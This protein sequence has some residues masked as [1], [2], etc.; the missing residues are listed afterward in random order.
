MEILFFFVFALIQSFP[1][2]LPP[3]PNIVQ[4]FGACVNGPEMILVLEYCGGG[5]KHIQV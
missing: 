1:R 3:H 4:M 5:T 2:E